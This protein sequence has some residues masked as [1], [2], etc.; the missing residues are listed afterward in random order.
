M[1]LRHDAGTLRGSATRR[2][3]RPLRPRA[4]RCR[5][6]A[7]ARRRGE[8]AGADASAARRRRDH[9]RHRPGRRA[10]PRRDDR[11]SRPGRC[12]CT[13][14]AGRASSSRRCSRPCSTG[15]RR[16]RALGQGSAQRP[17]GLNIARSCARRDAADALIGRRLAELD[18]ERRRHRVGSPPRPARVPARPRVRRV[19]RQH[20][21][22]PRAGPADGAIVMAVAALEVLGLTERVAERLDPAVR[23][24]GRAGLRGRRVPRRRRGDAALWRASTIRRPRFASRSSGRSSPSSAPGARPRSAPTAPAAGCAASSPRDR[25]RRQAFAAF[26]ARPRRRAADTTTRRPSAQP[27]VG[28]SGR[29]PQR[30]SR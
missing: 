12:R 5:R 30:L 21:P 28:E 13:R 17:D 14:S 1:R 7:P 20:R 16:R 29:G 8:P 23:P 10:R 24:G 11:R 18:Q 22:P 2:R 6:A 26:N 27:A 25:R 9:G 4:E 3:Q 15:G 19:A